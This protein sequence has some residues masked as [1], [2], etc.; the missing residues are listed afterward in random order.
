MAVK[1]M[2]WVAVEGWGVSLVVGRVEEVV[3]RQVVG[4]L[5]RLEVGEELRVV[6]VVLQ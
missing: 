2:F 5:R 4:V 1:S 6:E 3:R